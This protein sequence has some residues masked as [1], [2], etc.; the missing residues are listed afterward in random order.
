MAAAARPKSTTPI[1]D[2]VVTVRF[3]Q[4][5]YD[6]MT[7][8]RDRDGMPFSEQIRRA[9]DMFLQAKG[10]RRKGSKRT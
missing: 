2:S 3:D 9:L 7:A 8:L 10:I 5:L 1:K 4:E 6:D